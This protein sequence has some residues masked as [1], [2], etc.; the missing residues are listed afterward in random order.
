M[1][2]L[3][4]TLLSH[5][6]SQFLVFYALCV[7]VA[8]C[9]ALISRALTVPLIRCASKCSN[10]TLIQWALLKGTET[11]WIGSHAL[12]RNTVTQHSA[13]LGSGTR[14]CGGKVVLR[15]GSSSPI[16]IGSGFKVP[17]GA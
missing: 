2:I 17:C 4:C 6:A 7:S 1:P 5:S 12:F 8:M 15:S 14:Q 16:R 13:Q 3:P 10:H 9:Y 11:C